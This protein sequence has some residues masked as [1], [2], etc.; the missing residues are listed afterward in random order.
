MTI[1]VLAPAFTDKSAGILALYNLYESLA[2][3]DNKTQIIKYRGIG[4]QFEIELSSGAF[5][6]PES[7][8]ELSSNTI[9]VVPEVLCAS[10]LQNLRI[11]RY[12]LNRLGAIAPA[13]ADRSKEFAITF[14]I[15]Y[16]GL[17]CFYLPQ[18]L[19]G[20]DIPQD[21]MILKKGPR[22]I[23]ATYYGKNSFR[24][25][26]DNP[27]PT[28]VLITRDWPESKE[29]YRQLLECSEYLFSFDALSSTNADAILLGCLVVL[30]DFHPNDE[31]FF[32]KV[33]PDLPFLT[34]EN[35][36]SEPAIAEYEKK[37]N[38]WFEGLRTTRD[39]FNHRVTM[40]HDQLLTFFKL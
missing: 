23:N 39:Q 37:C 4:D 20:L 35:Y 11:A 32:K 26:H 29:Q 6:E 24:Y 28:S 36:G 25:D 31:I 33:S 1:A 27:L 8:Q 22:P 15:E 19:S 3:L 7:L 30:L 10:R 14:N 21:F 34:A 9:F 38:A 17:P 40:L 5:I 18:Y 12:Y 16:S 13:K 2:K